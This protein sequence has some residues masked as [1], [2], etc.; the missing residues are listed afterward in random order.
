MF[1]RNVFLIIQKPHHIN[2]VR[3]TISNFKEI[4]EKDRNEKSK[5]EK[6]R[7]IPHKKFK[8]KRM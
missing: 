1:K 2:N 5:N 3:V 7:E 8:V 4:R 6:N